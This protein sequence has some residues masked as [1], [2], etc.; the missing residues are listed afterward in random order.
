MKRQLFEW[1]NIFTNVTSDKGLTCKIYD[2][3]TKLNTKKYQNNLIKKW[4]K[5]L[6]KHFSKKDIQMPIYT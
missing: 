5:G 1:E 4:A 6:N 3:F 2:E